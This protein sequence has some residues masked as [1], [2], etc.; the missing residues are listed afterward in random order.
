MSIL[1]RRKLHTLEGFLPEHY[2]PMMRKIRRRKARQRFWRN[3]RAALG[4]GLRA[5]LVEAAA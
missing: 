2:Q 5:L 1:R 4:K 3:L